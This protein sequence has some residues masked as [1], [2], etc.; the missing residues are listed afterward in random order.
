MQLDLLASAPALPEGLRYRPDLI[1]PNEEAAL[2]AEVGA[3]PFRPFEFR[4]YLGNRRTVSFGYRYD[5][6]E[7]KVHEA[8]PIPDFLL[9]LRDRAAEFAGLVP[10]QLP[11]AL[12]TEYAPDAGIG[13]H[14]DR[15]VFEDVIGISL[16]AP[17]RFRLRR[18]QGAGWERAAID[19]AP[20]SAYLLR[21][22][23]RHEWQHSIAPMDDLRYSV[24]FRS[25]A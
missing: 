19:L 18:R 6:S 12:V 20:R 5:Y 14:R 2:V 9:P 7:Q 1:S 24:T 15:P 13:W 8:P 4:G 3:L 11:H 25:T 16:L 22:P 10:P 23:V 21:G 17:C